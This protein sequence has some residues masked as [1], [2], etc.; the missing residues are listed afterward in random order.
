M[1][2]IRSFLDCNVRVHARGD[3]FGLVEMLDVP[4]RSMPPLHVHRD[5]DE[6]FFVLEGEV[7][8]LLP[9]SEVTLT[10]GEFFLAPRGVPHSYRV[11]DHRAR[12]LCTSTPGRFVDFVDEVTELPEQ[13]P[14]V[15]G[16]VAA[17]H[18]IELLGPPGAVPA[19]AGA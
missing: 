4:A 19:A 18:G 15:V 3:D 11:G 17:A 14:D 13:S 6:G 1:T 12:W 2:A 5:H 9:E 10:A 16:T 7:T 8:L